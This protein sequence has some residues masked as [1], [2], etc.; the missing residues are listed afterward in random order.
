MLAPSSRRRT[1]AG[2]P[3]PPCPCR[4]ALT[5]VAIWARTAFY[6][7]SP[8]A[9]SAAQGELVGFTTTSARGA[10]TGSTL[11]LGYIKCGADGTPL[12]SPGEPGLVVEC[13]GNAWPLALLEK[14]PVA[15]GGRPASTEPAQAVAM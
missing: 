11:A 14:P 1:L 13:Y 10:V 7:L 4:H 3:L 12:A 6:A 8:L 15:V 2:V 9:A 5:A